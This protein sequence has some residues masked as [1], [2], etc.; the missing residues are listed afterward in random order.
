MHTINTVKA[1]V[2]QTGRWSLAQVGGPRS[3]PHETQKN[4]Y[5]DLG[6]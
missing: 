4:H 1:K 3:I 2:K 6:N 5:V